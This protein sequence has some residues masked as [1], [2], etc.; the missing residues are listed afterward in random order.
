MVLNILYIAIDLMNLSKKKKVYIYFSEVFLLKIL[1][2]LVQNLLR[3]T[4][5]KLSPEN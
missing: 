5:L 2:T 3:I 4:V 1:F